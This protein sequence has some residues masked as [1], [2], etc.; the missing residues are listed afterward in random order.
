MRTSFLLY[1]L[2]ATLLVG[3]VMF[4][5]MLLRKKDNSR[6][7]KITAIASFIAAVSTIIVGMATIRVMTYEEE[8]DKLQKQPLYSV[9]IIP[10][11]SQEKSFWDNEEFVITNE[12]EKTKSRTEAHRY[13]FI[14]ISYTNTNK[15]EATKTRYCSINDYFGANFITGNLDGIVVRSDYSGNNNE[16]FN[17]IYREALDFTENHP[18]VSLLVDKEHYFTMEYTDIFGESH[19]VVKKGDVEVDAKQLNMVRQEADNNSFSIRHLDLNE[20]LKSCLP[21]ALED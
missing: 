10:H 12:G 7:D 8:R 1:I 5:I 9:S 11:Y 3:I 14:V 13:S 6:F 19:T 16:L 17:I 20:I 4:V 15:H 18:G 21:E 2:F